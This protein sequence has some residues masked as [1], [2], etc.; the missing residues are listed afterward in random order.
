[1]AGSI[2]TSR[3]RGSYGGT[4]A[5]KSG[6]SDSILTPDLL[7]QLGKCIVEHFVREAMKDFAKRGWSVKDPMGGPDLKDSFSFQV[8]GKKTIEVS[9]S[10]YGLNILA[11][12]DIPQHPMTWLTQEAHGTP[13]KP[14]DRKVFGT[15]VTK[16][17]TDRK[18]L[19]VPLKA[20]SGEVI[21]RTAPLKFSDAWVHPG[22]AKFNFAERA[23]KKAREDCSQIVAQAA[24]DAWAGG[25]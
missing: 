6:A 3:M 10:F 25:I 16:R 13:K 5:K 1:M 14:P 2:S 21:F 18:P 11:N 24:L 15:M 4:H 19:V 7:N 22:I 9:S 12:Q 23:M 8:R 17:K 20:E